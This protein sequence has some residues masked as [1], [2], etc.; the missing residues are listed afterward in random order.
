[1]CHPRVKNS[2]TLTVIYKLFLMFITSKAAYV[3]YVYKKSS[4]DHVN[5]EWMLENNK[6]QLPMW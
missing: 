2:Y 5:I 6:K 3:V 4:Y 1:M